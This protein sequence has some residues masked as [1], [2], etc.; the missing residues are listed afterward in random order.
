MTILIDR[1]SLTLYSVPVKET[2]KYQGAGDQTPV[3]RLQAA[4]WTRTLTVDENTGELVEDGKYTTAW[5]I[6]KR[7]IRQYQR[8]LL[9]AIML[10]KR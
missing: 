10:I 5:S 2:I 4:C 8:Q 1:L 7:S 3:T 9:M 6:D